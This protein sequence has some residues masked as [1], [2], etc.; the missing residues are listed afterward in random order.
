MRN[1]P[2]VTKEYGRFRPT[3]QV[4]GM[5]I[6][7]R[8]YRRAEDAAS[9]AAHMRTI[10]D[11]GRSCLE[12]TADPRRYVLERL[13]RLESRGIES[14]GRPD[15][16]SRITNK[17]RVP[18]LELVTSG[19]AV[20]PASGTVRDRYHDVSDLDSRCQFEEDL[21]GRVERH[22]LG[23]RLRSLL[24]TPDFSSFPRAGHRCGLPTDFH[25]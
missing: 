2:N 1:F 17:K 21:F 11:T 23:K 6:R 9:A 12:F 20:D 24:S 5:R 15:A 3:F 4:K 18:D 8:R 25:T 13:R 16:S 14:E 10:I 7:G 22:V 19:W